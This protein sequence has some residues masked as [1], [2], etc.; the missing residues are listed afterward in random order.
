MDLNNI[1]SQLGVGSKDTVYLSVTPGVG[2]EL[3]QL[4]T[5]SRTVKN[6]AYRPLEYNESL[7]ELVDIEAFKNA[8][9]EL[10]AEL[11]INI[12][13]NVVLN[14]PM[15]LFAGKE[16]PLLLADDA[17][18][19]ALTSEV[20]QSYIFKRYE[21]VISWIDAN[22]SQSGDMRKLFYSAVQK[23]TIDDI[24]NALTE[25]GATLSGVEMSLTSI[26]KA[27]A[28]S[29]LAEEQMKE[30]I[31]WNLMLITQSGYSICSMIG[32]NIVDYYEE[33]LAIKS[34]EGD[35]IY[36]AINASAQIT[37]MSYPA[38][39]LYVISETDMVSAELLSKRLQT[40]G[41]VNFWENNSFK[42]Q[43]A[44][45]VSLEVLEETAHKISLEAIGIAVGSNVNMPVKFNFLSGSASEGAIDD[46]NEPV[47]VVLGTT[48]F[49]ISPNA[50]RNVALAAAVVL[51][52]PAIIAFMVVPMVAKQKQT[53]L[54]DVNAKLQQTDAEIK[55]LQEEQNKQNDFDVNAEIKKVLGNN[56]SKLMAYTALGES[57]PK[58]LWVTYFVAKDD[59]KF[60]IKGD[61]SNV[62]DIY[63][64]F[65]NMK[66]SLISTKLR[67]HKLEM[68]TESVDEAVTIDPNQ[69]ADYEFEITNMTSAELNPPPPPDPNAQ[70]QAQQTDDQK[71]KGGGLLSKPLLN[72][73]KSSN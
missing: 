38:N 4:D 42:K 60:D 49:D 2:L 69:P 50:A 72:F 25:L 61:S 64:F 51:L 52:I 34:F 12:K 28:F 53:L 6:Y 17:V 65:R 9:T 14:L 18:T 32:K 62:E 57:V 39:Y 40:D 16:L 36:N 35:E 19:E 31:S 66:D 68:K 63:L 11:K 29:G 24:K 3:I 26:L 45:P 46:P 73:G 41:I 70:Q 8:V 23:N 48:E 33:P 58:K 43:D 67:L 5:S 13:S 55:R 21:P 20:E 27:L 7:R 54:D 30:N 1:L 37:L 71:N 15:V 22:N 47:H 10:F 56:R 59:G 44:L